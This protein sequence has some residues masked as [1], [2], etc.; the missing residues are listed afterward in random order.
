MSDHN[1]QE[2]IQHLLS[3]LT[4]YINELNVL[5]YELTTE[6]L[7]FLL[8][9]SDI[10]D[11]LTDYISMLE[12]LFQTDS[13]KI[14]D[15]NKYTATLDDTDLSY[16]TSSKINDIIENIMINSYDNALYDMLTHVIIIH[17]NNNYKD[18]LNN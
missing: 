14:L 8:L 3:Q 1:N 2:Y 6:R 17:L 9:S 7:L 18:I 10:T 11:E 12:Y 13:M 16:F 5:K 15:I 4:N